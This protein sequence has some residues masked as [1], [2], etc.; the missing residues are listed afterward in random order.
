[1]QSRE[2]LKKSVKECDGKLQS[3][4]ASLDLPALEKELAQLNKEINLEGFWNNV[5]AAQKTTQ[6]AKNTQDRIE[7]VGRLTKAVKAVGELLEIFGDNEWEAL[8]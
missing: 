7:E 1:M 4:A 3:I 8:N 2:E 6:R 5:S